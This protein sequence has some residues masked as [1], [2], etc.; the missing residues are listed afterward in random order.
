[1]PQVFFDITETQGKTKIQPNGLADDL[2]RIAMARLWIGRCVHPFIRF[3]GY[4]KIK[5]K[6]CNDDNNLTRRT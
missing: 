6:I 1:V 4:E 5:G 2:G 3:E